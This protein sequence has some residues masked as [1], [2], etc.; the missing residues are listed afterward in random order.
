MPV[1]IS[2]TSEANV[3]N[4][5]SSATESGDRLRSTDKHVHKLGFTTLSDGGQNPTIDI[6]F[7]HGLQGHPAKTWTFGKFEGPSGEVDEISDPPAASK[8]SR[9]LRDL[10]SRK[11]KPS[12]TRGK[13]R[14]GVFWPES[15][16]KKHE[17]CQTARIMTYGYDSDVIRFVGGPANLNTISDNGETLLVGLARERFANPNRPLMF[18]VHSL[19]GLILKSVGNHGSFEKV[20]HA[21]PDRHWFVL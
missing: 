11:R 15:L 8:D 9:R 17:D 5:T 14:P 7:V 12:T 19:G 4:T 18:F 13:A 21:H 1:P 3:I 2:D 20:E 16:L 6:V 10:F